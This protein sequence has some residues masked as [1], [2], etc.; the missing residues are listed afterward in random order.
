MYVLNSFRHQ[1]SHWL[2]VGLQL[3]KQGE[4]GWFSNYSLEDLEC[5]SVPTWQRVSLVKLFVLND[6]SLQCFILPCAVTRSITQTVCL[7]HT[8]SISVKQAHSLCS[9]TLSHRHRC[10]PL[11]L[12]ITCTCCYDEIKGTRDLKIYSDADSQNLSPIESK[13]PTSSMR[14]LVSEH[15]SMRL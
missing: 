8:L 10:S 3:V 5:S 11:T 4:V 13:G 2:I 9:H 7:S 1:Q 6:R 14:V 15:A 12:T